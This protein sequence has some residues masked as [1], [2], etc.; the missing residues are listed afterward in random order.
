MKRKAFVKQLQ[1]KARD[2]FNNKQIKTIR[3]GY[4]LDSYVNWQNNIIL[5][6][7]V[8]YI[9]ITRAQRLSEREPFP[10]H[11]YIHHG[12]SSQ[13]C[14]F[15]LL[16]DII[17]SK[18]YQAIEQLLLDTDIPLKGKVYKAIFE[19]SD[20][21]IFAED[22]GQPT[23]VDLLLETDE[24]EKVFVEFKFTE[25]GFGGCYICENGDC[26]GT[27]PE[28]N[29]E[30]CSLHK[31][32]RKYLNLMEKYGLFKN[33]YGCQ[34]M[35]LYQAYRLLIFSLENKGHF[36]LIHDERNPAFCFK[37]NM[38]IMRGK[39]IRFKNLLPNSLKSRVHVLS[40]QQIVNNL[41]KQGNFL[42]IDEFK[43][44]YM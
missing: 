15:N 37:D 34:F 44:K 2:Y 11:K 28:S 10:L 35:D 27:N 41:E 25:P 20:R 19:Y 22:R 30:L 26:D 14:L 1:D 13:A 32:G 18:N 16:G 17:V 9:K 39:Y 29:Y 23:S 7:V 42:W 12:L 40:I 3:C 8:D 33:G 24:N 36:L 4:I 31:A 43:A 5:S 21:I 6:D 38:G